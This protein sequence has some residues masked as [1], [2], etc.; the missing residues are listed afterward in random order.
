[1]TI[2]GFKNTSSEFLNPYVLY[3][4]VGVYTG[5]AFFHFSFFV[6]E[7]CWLSKRSF[8]VIIMI[9]YPLPSCLLYMFQKCFALSF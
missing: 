3:C 2:K 6:P 7:T 1:M 5:P 4:K 8:K 9:A